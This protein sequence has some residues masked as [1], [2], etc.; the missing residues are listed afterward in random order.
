MPEPVQSLK[1]SL[2]LRDLILLNIS[3]VVGLG[4]LS[5]AAQLGYTS[6]PLYL[7]GAVAFL[8]PSGLMVAE[9]NARMPQEGGFY[10]W[11]KSAFGDI[12][13]YIAAWSYWLS[14]IVWLPTVLLLIASSAL[15]I[16]GDDY[17]HLMQD[18]RYYGSLSI[19]VLWVI[20]I[21]NVM[22]MER[23]KWIQNVGGAATWLVIAILIVV[24][25]WYM[26]DG[27]L[28]IGNIASSDFIPDFTDFTIIPFFAAIAF[29]F[30]GLELGPVMG[31]EIEKPEINVPRAIIISSI[32][33]AFLY[34]IGTGLL[35]TILPRGE[36]S[37]I[38]GMAQT[39]HQIS[40]DLEMPWI[41][42]VGTLIVVFG[43][44]GQFGA[45]LTGT[46]RLPFVVGLDDYLPKMMAEIHPRWG[47]PY[48]SVLLQGVVITFLFIAS[49]IGTT[50][51]EAFL[52]LYDMAIILYFIPF[53]Y[54]FAGLIVH[55]RRNDKGIGV[56]K[57]FK[58]N[59]WTIWVV[60]G[61]G[62]GM[63]LFALII[64]TIPT[65]EIVDQQ[66]FILKVVGGAFALNGLGLIVYFMKKRSQPTN[67]ANKR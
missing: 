6:L 45:W 35:V 58:S 48:I 23:A 37:V 4:S 36:I 16:M 3:S 41:V 47:S 19:F 9:L 43:T 29:S 61:V 39:F 32:T 25:I 67:E 52:I 34:M 30:G 24:G 56:I 60:G 46:A 8:I 51:K 18:Y 28:S 62:F 65:G 42:L 40:L 63:T 17:L 38:E 15:Y 11:T 1:K 27:G 7:L 49:T 66:L 54:M 44:I 55:V 64:A 53:L 21:L 33:V 50:I 31:D 13:G 20:V 22:G 5:Q 57:I 2:K 14:N 12:H 59:P 26:L 10:V